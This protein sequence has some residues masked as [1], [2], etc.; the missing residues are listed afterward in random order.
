[1]YVPDDLCTVTRRRPDLENEAIECLTF[2]LSLD[3]ENFCRLPPA[4]PVNT[5]F[6]DSMRTL[7]ADAESESAILTF[8]GDWNAKHSS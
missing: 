8:L 1:M 2:E 4:G 6:F 7:L 3:Q 5:S